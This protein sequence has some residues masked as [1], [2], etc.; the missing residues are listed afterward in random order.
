MIQLF[1]TV[2]ERYPDINR[3]E[4]VTEETRK[5]SEETSKL[6]RRGLVERGALIFV[7]S[8]AIRS[9]PRFRLIFVLAP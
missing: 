6:E 8:V 2:R 5:K 3:K 7:L 9:D 4:K 1:D